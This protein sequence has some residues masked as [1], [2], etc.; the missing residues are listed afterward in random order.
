MKIYTLKITKNCIPSLSHLIISSISCP[1]GYERMLRKVGRMRDCTVII[2]IHTKYY[3][4]VSREA[5]PRGDIYIEREIYYK[6][7]MAP[8]SST[9]TWK[10]PWMGEPGGLQSMGSLGVGHD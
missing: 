10:I 5:E 9:L 2:R 8:H 3:S 6:E 4:G 7:F 1:I